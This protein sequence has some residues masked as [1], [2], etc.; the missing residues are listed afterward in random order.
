MMEKK[1]KHAVMVAVHLTGGVL[2]AHADSDVW[3]TTTK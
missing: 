1:V 3:N 2:K